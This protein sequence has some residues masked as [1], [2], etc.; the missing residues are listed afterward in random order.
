M[1]TDKIYEG[2]IS[3]AVVSFAFIAL[4]LMTANT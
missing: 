2:V 3:W 4:F 1:K